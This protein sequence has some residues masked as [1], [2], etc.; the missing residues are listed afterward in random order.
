MTCPYSRKLELNPWETETVSPKVS[1]NTRERLEDGSSLIKTSE[2]GAAW[3]VPWLWPVG[4]CGPKLHHGQ[5]FGNCRIN[6][7]CSKLLVWH[8]W[9][10]SRGQLTNKPFLKTSEGAS[11]TTDMQRIWWIL[12]NSFLATVL[13]I[14]KHLLLIIILNFSF[15][16]YEAIF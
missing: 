3:L 6:A 5:T 15:L 7:C 14:Y 13:H 16:V 2:E 1:K 10:W 12:D 8:N 11:F 9:V 4:D